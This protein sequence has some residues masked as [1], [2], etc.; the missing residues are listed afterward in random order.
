[1]AKNIRK[2]LEE[3]AHDAGKLLLELRKKTLDIRNKIGLDI[4]TSADTAS[5]ELILTKLSKE[6]PDYNILA[7]EKGAIDKKSEY[8]FIID[9]LDGTKEYVR[10]LPLFNV[11]IALQH[12]K[13]TI[14]SAIYQPA[15]GQL[16]SA[17]KN[18]GSHLNGQRIVPS[19]TNSL[20]KAMVYIYLPSYHKNPKTFKRA[21]E[22]LKKLNTKVFRMQSLVNV[23]TAG[24]WTAM[25]GFDAYI[26][27]SNPSL[28]WDMAAGLFVAQEAGC[29]ITV[30]KDKTFVISN[31]KIHKEILDII[32]T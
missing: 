22:S 29:E 15:N 3:T 9:P 10:N 21:W 13:Q 18:E 31:G 14:A 27:N 26:N 7:E 25:G 1:M 32:T 4:V 12:K 11:A 23:N 17:I 24:C 6:F 20:A 30:F 2:I 5:E 8:T 19:D 16:F 28:P